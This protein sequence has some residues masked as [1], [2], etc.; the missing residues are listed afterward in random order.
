MFPILA[1]EMPLNWDPSA[2]DDLGSSRQ[3]LSLLMHQQQQQQPLAAVTNTAGTKQTPLSFHEQS[4][5]LDALEAQETALQ[6]A[7]QQACL[8]Q[9]LAGHCNCL[10]QQIK[11]I[12]EAAVRRSNAAAGESVLL[13]RNSN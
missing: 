6:E 2:A 12:A 13:A 8:E 3:A 10:L 9:A 11:A 5:L 1:A 4:A 7:Q